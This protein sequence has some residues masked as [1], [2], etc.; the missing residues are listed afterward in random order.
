MR[1]VLLRISLILILSGS[2]PT[3][4]AQSTSL[5]SNLSQGAD[6]SPEVLGLNQFLA[7]PF[8]TGS[9]PATFNSVTVQLAVS[10]LVVGNVQF[11][12]FS[13]VM[14]LPGSQLSGG[15]LNGPS[16]PQGSGAY[17]YSAAAPITLSPNTTYWVVGSGNYSTPNFNY[18]WYDTYSYN[19]SSPVGWQLPGIMAFS[20]D[21]GADWVSD[22]DALIP[23][24]LMFQVTG[25]VVPEPMTPILAGFG[26]LAIGL[27]RRKLRRA[28]PLT[29]RSSSVGHPFKRVVPKGVS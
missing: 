3:L 24:P 23:R 15:A 4:R 7:A 16:A 9:S 25:T 10:P 13:D 14:G 20:G 5:L 29:P 17:F 8:I 1:T 18:G 11:R 28:S 27:A 6:P 19:Y 2:G 12:L 22:A 26:L 21:Q